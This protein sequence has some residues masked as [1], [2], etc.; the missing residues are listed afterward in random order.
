[1]ARSHAALSFLRWG[2]V[3]LGSVARHLLIELRGCPPSV[4]ADADS[5]GDAVAEALE[6]LAARVMFRHVTV[7]ADRSLTGI[8]IAEEAHVVI[9][10]WPSEGLASADVMA[11]PSV[12]LSPCVSRLLATLGPATHMTLEVGRGI[13]QSPPPGVLAE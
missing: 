7:T 13:R 9:R 4:L 1:M 11:L 2:G 6:S 10:T 5:A 8:A 12:D 3:P